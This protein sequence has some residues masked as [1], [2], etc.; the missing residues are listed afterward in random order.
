M[1]VRRARA[2]E[3]S[4][5]HCLFKEIIGGIFIPK[6]ITTHAPEVGS[7]SLKLEKHQRRLGHRAKNLG[8]IPQDLQT[9]SVNNRIFLGFVSHVIS[10]RND[11][12]LSSWCRSS[13][14]NIERNGHGYATVNLI[15]QKQTV[16][17]SLLL[18][19]EK[20]LA[21]VKKFKMSTWLS[22]FL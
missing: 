4:T 15:L 20:R 12:A 1:W 17:H 13:T 16:G 11:S 18:H 5:D 22:T 2:L 7:S 6:N 3:P 9:F 10:C 14:D 8:G 19:V 21:S